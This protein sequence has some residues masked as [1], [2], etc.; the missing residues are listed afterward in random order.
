M[1]TAHA[2][3]SSIVFRRSTEALAKEDVPWVQRRNSVPKNRKGFQIGQ[4]DPSQLNHRVE[5]NKRF[6][7]QTEKRL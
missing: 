3:F 6:F 7:D 4:N 5:E 2:V 1:K